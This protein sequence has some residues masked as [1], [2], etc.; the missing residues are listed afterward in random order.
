[1][2]AASAVCS[3]WEFQPVAVS[4]RPSLVSSSTLVALATTSVAPLAVTEALLPV[5]ATR[6]TPS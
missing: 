6:V 4:Y 1:M 5:T 3:G 2:S